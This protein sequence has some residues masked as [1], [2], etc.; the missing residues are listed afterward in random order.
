[1]QH[2]GNRKSGEDH[3]SI[4]QP[5]KPGVDNRMG[6]THQLD[7]KQ[8]WEKEKGDVFLGQP[9]SA[10]VDLLSG[11][12]LARSAVVVASKSAVKPSL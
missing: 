2:H 3:N 12:I 11:N 1:M 4:V 6:N 8:Q 5:G 9:G 10:Q 7:I